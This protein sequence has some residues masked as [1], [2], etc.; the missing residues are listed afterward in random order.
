MDLK[1]KNYPEHLGL[2]PDGCRR[3]AVKQSFKPWKGHKKGIEVME[4]IGR[5]S[6]KNLPIKYYTAYGLSYENLNRSKSLLKI[7]FNLYS[8]HFLKLA[9]DE[10]IHEQ[11]VNVS[12]V[13]RLDLLPK[14]LLDAIQTAEAKTKDYD[15]KYFQIALAYSG[16]LE[17]VDAAEKAS[18]SGEISEKSISDNLYSD[19]PDA[20]LIIRT[21][22]KRI[23]NFLLWKGAYSE[24]YFID[25]YWPDMTK[26]DYIEALKEFDK[27]KRRYGE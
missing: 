14:K 10:T 11:E 15:K 5:W 24:L 19:F 12:A 8:E 13:G 17:I 3:W 18:E 1:I 20:D 16:R 2:I 23:S 21:S 4:D 7:L 6:F 27:R 9:E 22:E 25:K 26:E